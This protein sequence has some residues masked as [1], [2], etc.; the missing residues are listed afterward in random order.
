MT[1]ASKKIDLGPWFCHPSSGWASYLYLWQHF[2]RKTGRK[3]LNNNSLPGRLPNRCG[4][5]EHNVSQTRICVLFR[6]A[7]SSRCMIIFKRINRKFSK[8]K[9]SGNRQAS[10]FLFVYKLPPLSIPSLPPRLHKETEERSSM[11]ANLDPRVKGQGLH[12]CLTLK[13]EG[14][15]SSSWLAVR[16]QF[17]PTSW[18]YIL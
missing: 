18:R 9:L 11:A 7:Y 10:F 16:S 3:L 5:R 12:T 8:H 14:F 4:C 17:Y 2:H 15:C 6:F 13:R 1:L